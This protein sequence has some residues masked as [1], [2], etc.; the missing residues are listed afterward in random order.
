VYVVVY[1]ART[2]RGVDIVLMHIGTEL[3]SIVWIL[4]VKPLYAC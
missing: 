2:G 4:I 1:S 3:L